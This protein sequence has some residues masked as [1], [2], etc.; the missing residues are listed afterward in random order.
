MTESAIAKAALWSYGV[1][2][3]G[4]G[5]LSLR[6][7]FSPGGTRSARLLL[8][9]TLASALW[10]IAGVAVAL[11]P[12]LPVWIA[13]VT[14][15]TV[16]YAIWFAFIASVLR[17]R[18]ASGATSAL[19]RWFVPVSCIAFLASIVFVEPRPFTA[20]AREYGEHWSYAAQLALA[21]LGLVLIEQVLR[22]VDARFRW[23]LRPLCLGLTGLFAF[24]LLVYADALMFGHLDADLW[25]ARGVANALV[26]PFLAISA[27]RNPVWAVDLHL[28]RGMV[29][30]STAL[31]VSGV[32]LLV[33]ATTGFLVR[34]LGGEWAKAI[35]VVL[36]FAALLIAAFV[37]SSGG[38]RAKLRVFVSKHFFSYR[39][40][41][42]EVWLRFTRSLAAETS[43]RAVQE[44]CV[45]ALA[46][47]VESPGGALWLQQDGSY[48]HAASCNVAASD[49]VVPAD[50]SL[51]GFLQ[52]TGWVV[53]LAEH[54][55]HPLRYRDLVVPDWILALPGA[56][57][58][59]PLISGSSLLGFV[60]LHLPRATI[61]VNWEVRDLLKTASSQAASYLG[62]VHATESLLES[63]KFDAFNRMSAFVVHDLKNLVAQLSL[64]L[65][66]AERHRDNP[67]FQRDM[68]TTVDHVV[69]GMNQL[70][71]QLRTGATPVD[72][73]HSV[74]L[75]GVVRRVCSAK[76]AHPGRIALDL[77]GGISAL[78]HQDRLDHVVG[79]VIQNALDATADRGT[80]T[81]RV[82]SEP[83][84]A[85]LEVV[86][87]GVGMSPEFVRDRLFKPFETS[88][89]GGMGI[90]VYESAQ[91]IRGLGGQLVV[92]SNLGTGTRVRVLLPLAGASTNAHAARMEAENP[93][94]A[95]RV[96]GRI[97]Q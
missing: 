74:D 47:L 11:W 24:D 86:D 19:P 84:H 96:A 13:G 76:S 88:K 73:P 53:D 90:G 30:H 39:Y 10:A 21:I 97:V 2:F 87:T 42:R 64:M 41:Y 59:V 8:A 54:R 29:F 93:V 31:L 6:L 36:W 49:G 3:A 33:V 80:V 72:Q 46:D 51:A 50:S 89:S 1:A 82:A 14:F 60:I 78:G 4:F 44:R 27:A 68:L 85:V 17:G 12:A 37:A 15:D 69:G 67:E 57:L 38:F 56:W 48:A 23:G 61:H 34:Y 32:F 55:Q 91:Y 20:S 58:I 92:D 66:N 63:R 26:I 83:P 95:K 18:S 81:V 5:L 25:V 9:A 45:M 28:S 71:L 70:M 75:E 77:A 79:H 35:Q 7:V 65:K 40:D 52:R 16:R 94:S 43:V 22:R 62:H